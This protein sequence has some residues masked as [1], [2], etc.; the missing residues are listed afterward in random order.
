[1]FGAWATVALE[2]TLPFILFVPHW[3]KWTFPLGFVLHGMFFVVLPVGTF[4]CTMFLLYLAYLQPE[5]LRRG[6]SYC[7]DALPSR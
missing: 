1:M 7:T 5:T 4:T 2:Y 3:H 6:L